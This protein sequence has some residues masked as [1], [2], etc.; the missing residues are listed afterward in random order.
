M[1][2]GRGEKEVTVNP[3]GDYSR[4][5]TKKPSLGASWGCYV[6]EGLS[7]IKVNL[8]ELVPFAADENVRTFGTFIGPL[9]F[10]YTMGRNQYLD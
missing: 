1:V 5:A 6:S 2:A 10:H 7:I 9:R 8:L 4:L 3:R